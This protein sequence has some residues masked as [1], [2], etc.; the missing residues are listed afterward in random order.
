MQAL[1]HMVLTTLHVLTTS[2]GSRRAACA[3]L[4]T[5]HVLTTSGGSRRAACVRKPGPLPLSVGRWLQ[6]LAAKSGCERR[7]K[8][9]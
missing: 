4:T 1:L 2:G 3:V 9:G 6:A 7:S 8:P 5:L